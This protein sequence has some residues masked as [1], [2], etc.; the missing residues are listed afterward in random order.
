MA[1]LRNPLARLGYKLF[2][3]RLGFFLFHRFKS[4][5]AAHSN[6]KV[7]SSGDI[8]VL[9]VPFA[10][11]NYAYLVW[12]K[13][14]EQNGVAIDVGE[15]EAVFRTVQTRDVRVKNILTTH[16]HW[17]HSGGVADFKSLSQMHFEDSVVARASAADFTPGHDV[18]LACGE[19][20]EIGG[21]TVRVLSASCHTR[22]HVAFYIEPQGGEGVLFTGD[23]LFVGG[24][25]KFFEGDAVQM[26][27]TFKLMSELP[28][29]TLVF[30]GHEYTVSNYT[31]ALSKVTN[32]EDL[33]R[34]IQA[35]LLWA[36]QERRCGRP[37]VPS[38]LFEEKKHKCFLPN[39]IF[40]K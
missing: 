30:C 8:R 31:F 22:G 37:T 11:D 27:A 35:R 9:P 13:G 32:T 24:C 26:M 21:M 14:H 2:T 25:G 16:K 20:L 34:K 28:R 7:V 29:S 1:S 18:T 6:C 36:Q 15:A 3:S 10:T 23:S 40:N 19:T 12:R 5:H 39:S 4:T 38:T 17:D 33:H